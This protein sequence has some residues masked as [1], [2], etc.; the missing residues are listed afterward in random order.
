MSIQPKPILTDLWIKILATGWVWISSWI[1]YFLIVALYWE[2]TSLKCQPELQQGVLC[3]IVSESSPIQMR[4]R[5]IPKT[6]LAE[7]KVI[8]QKG[9]RPLSRVVLIGIDRQEIPLTDNWGGSV[10]TQLKQKIDLINTFI[11]DPQAQTLT[12]ETRRDIPLQTIPIV[13]FIAFVNMAL[14][15]I[16][17]R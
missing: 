15:K 3:N 8:Y 1:C 11:A 2:T 13:G 5:S 4:R 17:W 6:Q 9:R 12:V 7:V 10:T 14:L 16:N